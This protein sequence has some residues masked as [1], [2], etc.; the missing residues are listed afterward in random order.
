MAMIDTVNSV[1]WAWWAW[2][3]P[4]LGQTSLL[5]ALVA[6]V[7]LLIRRRVWPQVR[8]ALW[9]L[10][11]VKLVLPPGL[12][13]QTSLISALRGLA[14]PTTAELVLE[15][16]ADAVSP[17]IAGTAAPADGGASGDEAVYR[18]TAP[19]VAAVGLDW[20]VYVAAGWLIGAA[21]LVVLL[22]LGL[23][24]LRATCR[25]TPPEQLPGELRVALR[26]AAARLG[27]RRMPRAILSSRVSGP[28]VFGVIRP[29]LVL[30]TDAVDEMSGDELEHVL[31]HELAH[32]RRGDLAVHAV[33][34]LL[35]VAYWFHPLLWL[36]RRQLQHLR[37]LCCDA[38]VGRILRDQ[39]PGYS[40]TLRRAARRLLVRKLAPGLGLMG[41]FESSGRL[42]SRLQWLERASWRRPR[43]RTAA[44]L[45]VVALM[46]GC[47]LPMARREAPAGATPP[48]QTPAGMSVSPVGGSPQEEKGYSHM[49]AKP[50]VAPAKLAT[51]H[52]AC[53]RGCLDSLGSDVSTATLYGVSGW[54]W[55]LHVGP[56]LCPSGISSWQVAR[57]PRE[58]LVQAGVTIEPVVP[59]GS[60]DRGREKAIAVYRSGRPS[61][62][63]HYV[64]CTV[65]EV[66]ETGLVLVSPFGKV[67]GTDEQ[68]VLPFSTFETTPHMALSAVSLSQPEPAM[69]VVRNSLEFAVRA[70]RSGDGWTQHI[71]GGVSE[72]YDNWIV[73]AEAAKDLRSAMPY[74]SAVWSECKGHAVAFLE[75]SRGDVPAAA[76]EPLTN[77]IE[78]YRAAYRCLSELAA[79]FPMASEEDRRKNSEDNPEDPSASDTPAL[80]SRTLVLLRE[81]KAAEARGV[82]A[83]GNVLQQIESGGAG[84][85]SR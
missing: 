20:R 10:V 66:R 43:L 22:V 51:D 77:A 31:L 6:G 28:A 49:G 3:W 48:D 39:A 83:L 46:G 32:I 35:Q 80:R 1:A 21:V 72:S 63:W 34:M 17:P 25:S 56:D 57:V 73:A 41:L 26:D 40:E 60:H 53:V 19:A 16:A 33:T 13:L 79:M 9:L 81:A 47:I 12:A 42:A 52:M 2:M 23:R 11:L 75:E 45:I 54:A 61:Y 18:P 55:I 59:W 8:Y 24:R 85:S 67:G 36:V 38:T 78:A 70:F 7:D 50:A 15:P 30:P 84:S 29:V 74:H 4:M 44:V 69:G 76:Q 27:L 64:Y 14:A 65:A 68:G 71:Q 62:L 58:R 5:I 37:E 82:E